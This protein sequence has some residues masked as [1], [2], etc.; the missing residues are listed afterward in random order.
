MKISALAENTQSSIVFSE[1]LATAGREIVTKDITRMRGGWPMQ[2]AFYRI[3]LLASYYQVSDSVGNKFRALVAFLKKQPGKKISIFFSSCESVKHYS[4][5]LRAL[6]MPFSVCE[7]HGKQ[8]IGINLKVFS[9]FK[10]QKS[11]HILLCSDPIALGHHVLP[12]VSVLL[13]AKRRGARV[14]LVLTDSETEILKDMRR[15]EVEL[16]ENK[17]EENEENE[18]EENEENARESQMITE[19]M[20]KG[21]LGNTQRVFFCLIKRRGARVM[22]VLTD[23]ETE[24]LKDMRRTEMELEENKLEEN[25]ENELEENE[26]NAR[27]QPQKV[28]IR[29]FW[30]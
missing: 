5:L 26:E 22:L 27:V 29:K 13:S 8:S 6:G 9:E 7:I 23:S 17:L 3:S 19:E 10:E 18:L 16:E 24:I 14:I 1:V 20:E 2:D 4:G 21:G 11:A 28:R 12:G 30:F 15:T 25:E